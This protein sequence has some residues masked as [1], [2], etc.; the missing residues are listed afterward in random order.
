MRLCLS[1]QKIEQNDHIPERFFRWAGEQQRAKF[2]FL[3]IIVLNP[4]HNRFSTEFVA[5]FWFVNNNQFYKHDKRKKPLALQ[6]TY[7]PKTKE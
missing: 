2:Y 4:D 7:S 1:N 6:N 5:S 3:F